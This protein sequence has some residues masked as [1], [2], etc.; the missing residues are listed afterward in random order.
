MSDKLHRRLCAMLAEV[1][2][3]LGVQPA[4]PAD[5]AELGQFAD[6]GREQA[7]RLGL[8]DDDDVAV[9]VALI[10]LDA[11]LDAAERASFRSWVRPGLDQAALL[12]KVRLALAERRLREAAA[13]DALALRLSAQL[14]KV[15]ASFRV[16]AG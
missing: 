10:A 9:V 7:A 11:R 12:G 16:D 3:Q 6:A 8:A 2:Q 13:A 14:D 1:V 4:A 5:A 15:R